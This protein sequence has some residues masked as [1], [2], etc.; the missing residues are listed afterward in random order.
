[1]LDDCLLK[2]CLTNKNDNI[3]HKNIKTRNSINKVKVN[4]FIILLLWKY[5]FSNIMYLFTSC[6]IN[7]CLHSVVNLSFLL[8]ISP[9]ICI[10]TIHYLIKKGMVGLE[11]TEIASNNSTFELLCIMVRYTTRVYYT[12]NYIQFKWWSHW[13]LVKVRWNL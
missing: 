10:N 6:I 8:I 13:K 9:L 12:Q 3:T 4:L 11:N 2:D 7:I 5:F 1:M